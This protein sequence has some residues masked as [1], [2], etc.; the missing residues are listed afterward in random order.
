MWYLCLGPEGNI[1]VVAS[2][3]FFEPEIFEA[4]EYD[5]VKSEDI[6]RNAFVCAE[7]FTEFLYRFWVENTIWYSL[8]K[9]LPLTSVQEEYRNQ[10]T[11]RL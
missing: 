7:T 5:G 10:I 1:G 3:Y 6:F 8:H 9:Q 4:M 2:H 11:K